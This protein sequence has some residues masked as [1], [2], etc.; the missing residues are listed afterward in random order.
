M[1]FVSGRRPIAAPALNPILSRYFHGSISSTGSR[2]PLAI[3]E[4]RVSSS[5][6]ETTELRIEVELIA[7]MV[8]INPL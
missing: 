6:E 1:S 5:P 4:A 3:T 8:V 7:D 2:I